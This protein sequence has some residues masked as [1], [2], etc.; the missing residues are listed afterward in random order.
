MRREVPSNRL[1][2]GSLAGFCLQFQSTA[3]L[4]FIQPEAQLLTEV[5]KLCVH[6]PLADLYIFPSGRVLLLHIAD[7]GPD[8][9][10]S[11]GE[12]CGGKHDASEGKAAPLLLSHS[13]VR[14][15]TLPIF[16]YVCTSK[17]STRHFSGL[18]G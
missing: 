1:F 2:C 5:S 3:R 13:C 4:Q 18:L 7:I 11:G 15:N 10:D 14:K 17:N 8:S 16:C 6:Y 12:N 9:A